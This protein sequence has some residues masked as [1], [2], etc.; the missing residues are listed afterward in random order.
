MTE[1]KP[2]PI[3]PSKIKQ[4]PLDLIDESLVLLRTSYD[5]ESLRELGESMSANGQLYPIIV[6]HTDSERYELII[7]S[8]RVRAAKLMEQEEI[9]ATIIEPQSSL[10]SLTLALAENLHREDLNPFEE[11]QAFL[12]LAKD[13]DLQVDEI[14]KKV[15]K[16]VY[17]VR[18][19]LQLL[20]FPEEVKT[21]FS[22]RELNLAHVGILARISDGSRQV[23][24]AKLAVENRLTSPELRALIEQDSKEVVSYDIRKREVTPQKIASKVDVF[25]RWIRKVPHMIKI[26]DLNSQEKD[27]VVAALKR[28]EQELQ[29]LRALFTLEEA[30]KSSCEFFSRFDSGENL[31]NNRE[32]WTT[33]HVRLINAPNRPSD[34]Q[35][36]REIGRSVSAIRSM[37]SKTK[38]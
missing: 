6:S 7:G 1:T 13:Y 17:F 15:N 9:P 29:G 23:Y 16:P 3:F 5:E 19:R 36:A 8:R 26:S 30:N 21:L 12:H 18:G 32:E 10:D 35:L 22:T 31:R 14:A 38:G 24:Y 20:S 27:C 33:E 11:A 37:R 25:G 34:E 28:A 4:I 2:I